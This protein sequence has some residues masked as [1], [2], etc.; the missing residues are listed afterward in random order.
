MNRLLIVGILIST[1]VPPLARAQQRDMARL[2]S[3]AQ[4][5][6]SIIRG[7]KAKI[8]AYS[9]INSLGGEIEQAAQ[10]RDEQKAAFWRRSSTCLLKK[11]PAAI[12]CGC[13]PVR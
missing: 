3:N 6:V 2:K 10:Q 13:C 1:A 9:Q 12:P 7:D 4:K 8:Q 11:T 5:V